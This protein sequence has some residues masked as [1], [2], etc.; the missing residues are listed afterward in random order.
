MIPRRF[1]NLMMKDLRVGGSYW[2]SRMSPEKNL[3]YAS[4]GE[5]VASATR[6]PLC[7]SV[8]E[9]ELSSPKFRFK[10]SRALDST[11]AFM[12]FYGVDPGP[13]DGRI[14]VSD[15]AGH[16]HLYDAEEGSGEMLPPTNE[17]SN[18]HSPISMCVAKEDAIRA[19]A[20]YA[21]NGRNS[22]NFKSLAY[23]KDSMDNE[24]AWD[25]LDLP[26][27]PYIS[28]EEDPTIQS[29]T[30]LQDNR[31]IC[32]SSMTEGGGFGTYCFDTDSLEWTKAG[33]WTLPFVGRCFSLP[34]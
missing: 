27:P 13:S 28:G 22:T 5:A 34:W 25:W 24:M 14:V 3:F 6:M 11:F 26:P 19:D 10:S 1:I 20:L 7:A 33:S 23:R 17:S 15:S 32:F 12:P 21:I 18:W 31:T 30:L 4:V 2:L 29:Y 8:R 9:L 16:T